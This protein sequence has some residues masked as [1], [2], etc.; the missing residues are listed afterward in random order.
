MDQQPK[1]YVNRSAV[2][3]A[4]ELTPDEHARFHFDRDDVPVMGIIND[5]GNIVQTMQ[6]PIFDSLYA[7]HDS[8]VVK[9]LAARVERLE[10][11]HAAAST[12]APTPANVPASTPA[13]TQDTTTAAPTPDAAP[14]P[15]AP[16]QS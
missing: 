8:A 2:V 5:D 15:Q 11:T 4:R 7:E 10:A 1:R 14:S 12:P 3:L 16:P 6:Q 9:D 13:P